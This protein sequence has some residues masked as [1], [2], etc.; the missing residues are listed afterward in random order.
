MRSRDNESE[1]PRI[2]LVLCSQ[3]VNEYYP[4]LAYAMLEVEQG[5]SAL[6]DFA[7]VT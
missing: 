3:W 2:F 7:S 1:P 4:L 5:E 6:L